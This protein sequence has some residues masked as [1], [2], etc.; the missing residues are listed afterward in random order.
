MKDVKVVLPYNEA[1]IVPIGDIHIGDPQFTQEAEDKLR[2]YINWVKE[3][4]NA[5]I[6]LMGDIFNMATITSPSSTFRENERIV[7]RRQETGYE[8]YG[9]VDY[10]S[11]LFE[12][13]KDKIITAIKGNHEN[14]MK[15]LADYDPLAVFCKNL[16]IVYSDISAVVYAKVGKPNRKERPSGSSFTYT[17][18][19][20]HTTGGGGS[21]G[22]KI[23]RVDKLR[24]IVSG[25]DCYLGGH[26]HGLGS[27]WGSIFTIDKAN[28]KTSQ[29]KHLLATT[30]SYLAYK[31]GY[32]EEMMLAP[33]KL[34]SPRI[35]LSGVKFD[36]HLSE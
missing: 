30:G 1:Y 11:E 9:E 2:G 3:H 14:R 4:E 28:C 12:P 25:C 7:K 29:V 13:V 26:N 31:D 33:S 5:R 35:R 16:G 34:G 27:S 32:A 19:A 21:A 8:C 10:A 17:I 36:L 15:K 18:Y 23:N 22:S 20:H 24:D 6:I